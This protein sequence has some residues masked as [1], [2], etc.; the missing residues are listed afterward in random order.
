MMTNMIAA[1]LNY[2]EILVTGGGVIGYVIWALSIVTVALAI[3]LS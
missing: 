2:F 1:D 3:R